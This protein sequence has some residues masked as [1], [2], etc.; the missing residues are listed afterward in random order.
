MWSNARTSVCDESILE[1]TIKR[2]WKSLPNRESTIHV[3][4]NS[5]SVATA[6]VGWILWRLC[7][8]QP[9]SLV[10]GSSGRGSST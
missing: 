6:V 7:H 1:G 5:Y 10:A 4:D 3:V 2:D 8:H 9:D